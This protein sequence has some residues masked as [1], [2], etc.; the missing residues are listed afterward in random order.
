MKED[1]K[2]VGVT[3]RSMVTNNDLQV[4]RESTILMLS[5]RET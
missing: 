5:V 4:C 1:M 3:Q 2:V